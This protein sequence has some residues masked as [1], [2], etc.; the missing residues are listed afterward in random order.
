MNR[1]VITTSRFWYKVGQSYPILGFD[2]KMGFMV[3][4][5]SNEGTIFYVNP[6]DCAVGGEQVTDTSKFENIK[7]VI[8]DT[9]ELLIKLIPNSEDKCVDFPVKLEQGDWIDLRA[10]QSYCFEQGEIVT[11]S[12]GIACKLPQGYEAYIVPR[13]SLFRKYGLTLC[14]SIGIID[15]KN[16]Y[17]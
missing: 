3:D 2:K 14:N 13:S 11:I 17:N 10:S 5:N 15:G 12:F 6:S 9:E 16:K 1:L 7:V 4:T 8:D